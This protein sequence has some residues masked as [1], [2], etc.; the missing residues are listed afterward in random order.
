MTGA[1]TCFG[2]APLDSRYP[3]VGSYLNDFSHVSHLFDYDPHDPASYGQRLVELS[4][5]DW[6][7]EGLAGHLE[8]YNRSLGAPPATLDAARRLARPGSVVVI[9]GQQPGVLT[10]PLYTFW[11]SLAV[12]ELAGV[13]SLRLGPGVD[14]VPVFWIGAEDHDL[15]EVARFHVLTPEGEISDVL[16]DPAGPS[17]EAYPE[18]ASV[19]HL[20]A[21]AAA[22]AFLDRLAPLLWQTEFTPGVADFL[23]RAAAESR[24][25]GE[26]FG[27][28]LLHLFGHLGL[29]VANPL[30]PE[31]R[32]LERPAFEAM[33][34]DNAA[35]SEAFERGRESVRELGLT[36][37]VDK[38]PDAANLYLYDGIERLPLYRGVTGDGEP[39]FL[40]DPRGDSPRPRVLS[41]DELLGI[42][43][44][45]PGRLSTNVVLRPLA[46]DSVFPVLAYVGGPGE[47]SYFA[48]YKGIYRLAG[49]KLPV[50]YPRPGVTLVEPAVERHLSR[51]G[52]DAEKAL[53]PAVLRAAKAAYLEEADPVGIDALFAKLEGLTESAYAEVF[54]SMAAVDP[55]LPELARKNLGRVTGEMEWLR[56]KA[57]QQHRQNCRDAVRRFEAIENSFRP[58]GD[59]QERVYNI[60]PY[61]CKYGPDLAPALAQAP[62][63]PPDGTPAPGHCFIRI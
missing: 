7:R 2:R 24:N 10:G 14:V 26:W 4:E 48:L 39:V 63:V 55:S 31:L 17:G 45:E 47:I 12:V 22:Q 8:A 46:Q 59:F 51:Y 16:Y 11:K 57:W 61:L 3:L 37:Q 20:P 49:R 21:G 1:R 44:R 13:L 27:R 28:L 15:H 34:R 40:A 56:K 50:I 38:D 36:P 41:Q 33:V 30:E 35:I 23:R 25:L 29:V 6:E 43:R 53:D 62:I 42:A 32:A 5:H 58:R 18:R 19:G 54:D 52:L 9:G 60:F